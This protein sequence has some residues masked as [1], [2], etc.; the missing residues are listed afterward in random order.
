MKSKWRDKTK[1]NY[2]SRKASYPGEIVS[3]DM[4]VSPTPG[5]IAQ[6]SSFLTKKRYKYAT[7]YIDNY[8]RLGY[9]YLQPDSSV[10]TT[11]KGKL[12]WEQ[13]AASQ[14]VAIKS[15]HADNGIFKAN[16]W[17]DNCKQKQQSITF[18]GV[19]THHQNGIA[20]RRIRLIQDQAQSIMIYAK[21]RWPEGISMALWP[22]ATILAS[23]SVN[24]TPSLQD[25]KRRT[26]LQI[27][28]KSEVMINPKHHRPFGCL[29]YVLNRA[30][31]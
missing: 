16:G 9:V 2:N 28:S 8:S 3:V 12:A 15:Y 22:Y 5:L 23:N 29:V 7:V 10:Q 19:N 14:G 18:A 25:E 31:Q 21:S 17:V 6:M 24:N 4:L 1:Q 20:E 30:L 13:Y 27:F 26:P 11:L